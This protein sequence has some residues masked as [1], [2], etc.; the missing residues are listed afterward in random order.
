MTAVNFTEGETQYII[1]QLPFVEVTVMDVLNPI[2]LILGII[3]SAMSIY[4]FIQKR[5]HPAPM[6]QPSRPPQQPPPAAAA[7]AAEPQA[8]IRPFSLRLRH[9]SAAIWVVLGLGCIAEAMTFGEPVLLIFGCG[10][11]LLARYCWRG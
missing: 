9:V 3:S 8:S 10:F 1:G 11:L 7:S 4:V 6:G 5:M 2:G